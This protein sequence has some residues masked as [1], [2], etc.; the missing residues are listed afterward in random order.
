MT[1]DKIAHKVKA[2]STF[3]HLPTTS[4]F[5]YHYNKAKMNL[6]LAFFA[7]TSMW[8]SVQG[9]ETTYLRERDVEAPMAKTGGSPSQKVVLV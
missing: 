9:G 6:S 5:I 2:N 1:R 4:S 8:H 7:F 3:K